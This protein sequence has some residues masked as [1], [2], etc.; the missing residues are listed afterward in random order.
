M[1]HVN[2]VFQTK[3]NKRSWDIHTW[4]GNE[5]SNVSTWIFYIHTW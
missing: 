1:L 4:H 2:Y 3:N 5:T